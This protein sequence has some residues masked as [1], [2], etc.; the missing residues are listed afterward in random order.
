MWSNLLRPQMARLRGERC[1]YCTAKTTLLRRFV[2]G[3]FRRFRKNDSP[4]CR[5][6]EARGEA[7][8]INKHQ[9]HLPQ[10]RHYCCLLLH[11]CTP[12]PQK[13]SMRCHQIE[14]PLYGELMLL[15]RPP[16]AR[17]QASSEN[18]QVTLFSSTGPLTKPPSI[19]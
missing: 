1:S 9:S 14:Y 5:C 15:L 3:R 7:Q 17:V 8:E 13:S 18:H 4:C 16:L 19:L 10:Q 2:E 11:P 6:C 12:S